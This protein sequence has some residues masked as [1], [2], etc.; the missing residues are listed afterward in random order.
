MDTSIAL[1]QSA[2]GW[3]IVEEIL[4]FRADGSAFF[5]GH[6]HRDEKRSKYLA[7]LSDMHIAHSHA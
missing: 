2:N 6:L 4:G 3:V 5:I 7:F 1:F